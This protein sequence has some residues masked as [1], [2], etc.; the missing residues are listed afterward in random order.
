V[1]KELFT[2]IIGGRYKGKKI[3]LPDKEVTRSSKNILRESLFNVLQFDIVD[4]NFVEVFGGSGSV[5][6]EAL[7]RG[8][9]E[10]YF[11]EKD[12]SSFEVLK[13]NCESLDKSR[14]SVYYGDAFEL[15]FDIVDELRRKREKAYFYFD[16]PFSIRQ[17]YEDI[18]DRV[19]DA[20]RRIPKEV[21]EAIVIEHMSKIDF[22]EKIGPYELYKRKKFG[23]S[24]LSFYR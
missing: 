9:K 12:R 17:G 15:L 10:V 3:R 23:K 20:I 2:R 7:S 16:P 21:A 24:T 14:C 4:K 13:N 6:L 19:I 18:Y 8:A 5:G 22:P 1:R 11:I